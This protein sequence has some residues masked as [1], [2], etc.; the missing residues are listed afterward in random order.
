M[1]TQN[2]YQPVWDKFFP[3]IYLKLKSALKKQETEFLV[4]DKLDF[5]K[6][7][8]RK[9][10][11]Y[12]F[13]LEMNEGR[14]LKSKETSSVGIDF[15][16]AI[17]ENETLFSIVKVGGITF[18]LNNKF[19]LSIEPKFKTQEV[20]A[21]EITEIAEPAP[22]ETVSDKTETAEPEA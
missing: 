18:N 2:P 5:E 7:S 8:H 11:S 6:A 1:S 17:K 10:S 21:A 20:P 12:M 4:M 22:A 14:I 13:R 3:V 9:N 15:A 16:R 19:V